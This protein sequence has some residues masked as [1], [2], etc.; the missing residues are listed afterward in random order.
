MDLRQ[1]RYFIEIADAGSFSRAANLLSVA[2]PAL[3]RQIRLLEG[4]LDAPLFHR[5]GRG[6]VLTAAGELLLGHARDIL[7][8][9][10]RAEREIA[11][12]QGRPTGT[13]TLGVPPSV[14]AML[15]TPLVA[16]A[17]ERYPG[18]RLHIMEGFSGTVLDWLQTGRVD[19]AIIYDVRRSTSIIAETLLVEDLFLIRRPDAG[20]KRAIRGEA[21]ARVP[22]VLPA[23]PHGLRL[24][25]DSVMA[26]HGLALDVRFEIDSMTIMKELS[27]EGVAGTV[28]PFGAV[29]REVKAGTLAAVRIVEPN[30]SRTMVLAT[31]AHRPVDATVRAIVGAIRTVVSDLVT[32]E[33]W[34]GRVRA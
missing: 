12:L 9:T 10:A 25:C 33:R 31:A 23:K 13:V 6:V 17:S 21:L 2:Q 29:A 20:A 3:S 5:N 30:M 7:Q 32:T 19:L 1:L 24:L 14:A 27:Q 11:V 26:D 34:L 18:V 4:R 15:L 22:L 8:R 16:H 28:L